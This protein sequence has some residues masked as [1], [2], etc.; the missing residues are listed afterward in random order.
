MQN[1]RFFSHISTGLIALLAI[2]IFCLQV[3]RGGNEVIHFAGSPSIKNSLMNMTANP[4]DR[5]TLNRFNKIRF[6]N[7]SVGYCVGSQGRIL[8]T[9]DGGT[10]WISHESGVSSNLLSL[11]VLDET[12]I[13]VGGE[14]GTI[15]FGN[16]QRWERQL[17]DRQFEIYDIQF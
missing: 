17:A 8:S 5:T 2:L 12:H 3:A 9:E 7:S 14:D 4:E 6:L 10:N 15:L 11:F 13:W 16:G 1:Q